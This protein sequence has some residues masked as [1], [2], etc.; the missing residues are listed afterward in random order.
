MEI[1]NSYPITV[2]I[3]EKQDY[4]GSNQ[5][6]N[7]GTPEA[8]QKTMGGNLVGPGSYFEVDPPLAGEYDPMSN[9]VKLITPDVTNLTYHDGAVLAKRDAIYYSVVGKQESQTKE[10][11]NEKQVM[12]SFE[13]AV[14]I[15]RKI[16]RNF[17]I[18]QTFADQCKCDIRYGKDALRSLSID[19][20]SKFFLK[21]TADLIDE[22]NT[23]KTNGSHSS[24]TSAIMDEITETKYRNDSRGLDRARIIQ[25]LDPLPDKTQAEA[26][27][28]LDKKGITIEQ[29]IIKSQL[30]SFVKRFEREQGSLVEFGSL[31]D[32]GKKIKSIQEAFTSYAKEI[33]G[34]EP[35]EEE[36][37]E[38]GIEDKPPVKETD[39]EVLIKTDELNGNDAS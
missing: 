22:L 13:S 39:E 36:T 25:E 2:A 34:E 11:V 18:I 30:M 19:Y 10:A 3:R 16:A 6:D 32:Y 35:E 21:D 12:A 37:P 1:G 23:A 20:G 27:I 31:I 17:E 33:I 5:E 4:Q 15:L 14:N 28:I 9:P 8:E 26:E 24:I 7:R 29:F 38:M